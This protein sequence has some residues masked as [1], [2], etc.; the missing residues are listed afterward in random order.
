[1]K[2][3]LHYYLKV[4]LSDAQKAKLDRICR[5]SGLTVSEVIRGLLAKI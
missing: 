1:M 2:K 3:T 4:R 5:E